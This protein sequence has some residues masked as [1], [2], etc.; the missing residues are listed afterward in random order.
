MIIDES[1]MTPEQRKEV[2]KEIDLTKATL[3]SVYKYQVLAEYAKQ[4]QV[5]QRNHQ[6]EKHKKEK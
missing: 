1:D 6:N 5:Q 2:A 3:P 4:Q